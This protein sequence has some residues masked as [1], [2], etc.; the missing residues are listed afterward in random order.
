[1][2]RNPRK[3]LGSSKEDSEDIKRHPFFNGINWEDVRKRKL[4]PP[5]PSVDMSSEGGKD[6]NLELIY[7]TS[8]ELLKGKR[9]R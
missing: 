9:V 1:M 7:G 6:M 3:R 5:K 8:S 4:H 2:N